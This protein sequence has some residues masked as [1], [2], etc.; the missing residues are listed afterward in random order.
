MSC[1]DRR[2]E[3][4]REKAGVYPLDALV[5]LADYTLP[6]AVPAPLPP[7][8][9]LPAPSEVETYVYRDIGGL[10]PEIWDF[11]DFVEKNAWKWYERDNPEYT[12]VDRRLA[13]GA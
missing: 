3:Y 11:G 5:G 7:D 4:T 6:M 2:Q 12:E 13:A 8:A 1:A 10:M 9:A